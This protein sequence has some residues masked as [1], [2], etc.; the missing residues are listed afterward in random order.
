MLNRS[1]SSSFQAPGG[2]YNDDGNSESDREN[3]D[4]MYRILLRIKQTKEAL[5][6]SRI[7]KSAFLAVK[8]AENKLQTEIKSDIMRFHGKWTKKIRGVVAQIQSLKLKSEDIE[9]RNSALRRQRKLDV[10]QKEKEMR[11]ISDQLQSI[12]EQFKMTGNT[13][14][15]KL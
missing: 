5:E 9:E 8:E 1:N 15:N 2:D 10:N 6:E 11:I 13:Q 14:V 3:D 4:K 12:V 7:K